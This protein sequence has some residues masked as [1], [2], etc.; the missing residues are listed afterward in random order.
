MNGVDESLE[1]AL[2]QIRSAD[3]RIQN[4]GVDGMIRIGSEAVSALL[5]LLADTDSG[6]RSQATYALARIADPAATEA[7][8]RGPRDPDE[9]V[10]AY[11]AQGL[12]AIGAP[13]ALQACVE[14]LNDAP[15]ELHLDRTPAVEALGAMGI[16]AVRP[17]L[18]RMM[19]ADETTRLR[20]QRA[21]EEIV[22]RRHGFRAGEGFPSRETEAAASALWSANGGYDYAAGEVHRRDSVAK[23]RRW[24]EEAALSEPAK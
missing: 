6:V 7:F 24:L 13:D 10:R 17:V 8:R 19:D 5:P 3:A 15:D 16:D 14:T 23:W 4:Q 21:L 1:T 12:A 2:A 20:A 9:R 11:A 22:N 18:D